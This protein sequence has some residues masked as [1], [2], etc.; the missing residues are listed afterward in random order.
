MNIL[1]DLLEFLLVP[2]FA[3]ETP[4]GWLILSLIYGILVSCVLAYTLLDS[5]SKGDTAIF[6]AFLGA[7]LGMF[8]SALHFIR[9][10]NDRRLCGTTFV[11]NGLA[12][13]L[14]LSFWL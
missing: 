3:P 9:E 1:A 4:R 2:E 11:A 5:P 12:V 13:M 8:Y 7:P 6:L 10:P 14:A